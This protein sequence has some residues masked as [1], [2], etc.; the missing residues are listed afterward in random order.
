MATGIEVLDEDTEEE[1]PAWSPRPWWAWTLTLLGVGTALMFA[2]GAQLSDARFGTQLRARECDTSPLAGLVL[3]GC[4]SLLLGVAMQLTRLRRSSAVVTWDVLG[5]L[6][7]L[8]VP[9]A[10]LAATLPGM[11]GC[12]ISSDLAGVG[13]IGSA[14]VGTSGVMLC[15]SAVTLVGIALAGAVSVMAPIVQIL[16]EPDMPGIVELA[17]VEAEALQ[18][19]SAATRFRGVESDEQ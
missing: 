7:T 1:R 10:L 4:A 14:L 2:A 17:M 15:A 11:L 19:A 12:T 3:L 18:S 13:L 16:P 8:P 6:V 5:L 9:A